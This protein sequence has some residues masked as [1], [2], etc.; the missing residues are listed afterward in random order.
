MTAL[1]RRILTGAALAAMAAGLASA[2]NIIAYTVVVPLI[3][4]NPTDITNQLMQVTAWCPGCSG[5]LD[6]VGSNAE[7]AGY[8]PG[9]ALIGVTMN[10]LNPLTAQLQGFDIRVVSAITGNFTITNAVNSGSNANG[11][12]KEDSYTAVSLNSTPLAPALTNTTDPL[13]DLFNDG[14]VPGLGPDPASSP[15]AVNNL[16]PGASLS[17]AFSNAKQVVDFGCVLATSFTSQ[18]SS[19]NKLTNPASTFQGDA[20]NVASTDPLSFYFSTATEVTSSLTGGNTNTAN[21]TQVTEMVTVTYDYTTTSGV[22]EPATMALMGGALIGLGL[23][24]K[25]FKKS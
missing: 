20:V 18:C 8:G 15:L 16:A 21:T 7:P 10:S 13:N 17:Q 12:A 6:S 24:G 1:F 22:P 3:G 23:L 9:G 14:F 2:D 19:Y 25:R 4:G 5:A 11:T